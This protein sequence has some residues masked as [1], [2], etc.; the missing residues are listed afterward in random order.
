L[1]YLRHAELRRRIR[2][3]CDKRVEVIGR[4]FLDIDHGGKVRIAHETILVFWRETSSDVSES[5][6]HVSLLIAC[7][8]CLAAVQRK[9]PALAKKILR[10]DHK[11]VA[12]SSRET[13]HIYEHVFG[14]LAL[15][16]RSTLHEKEMRSSKHHSEMQSPSS[17][18]VHY[19]RQMEHHASTATLSVLECLCGPVL[20]LWLAMRTGTWCDRSGEPV[21]IGA[22]SPRTLLLIWLIIFGCH[23]SACAIMAS[24]DGTGQSKSSIEDKIALSPSIVSKP[25][26]R[27]AAVDAGCHAL[28]L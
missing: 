28:Y 22:V 14:R 25:R 24:I 27:E 19:V 9:Y 12:A 1:P 13:E 23:R 10:R 3:R 7:A 20:K 6:G 2:S 11:K 5:K 21:P 15:G 18:L 17:G 8:S 26:P 16:N 4:G